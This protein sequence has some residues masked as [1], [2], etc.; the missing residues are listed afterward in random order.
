MMKA[1]VPI[2]YRDYCAH[3]LI[4][5]NKCRNKHFYM[6]WACEHER[7]SYEVCEYNEWKHRKQVKR[8]AK[9]AAQE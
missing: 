1:K 8:E 5:L 9:R 2:A 6:P 4:R 7:H 3:L